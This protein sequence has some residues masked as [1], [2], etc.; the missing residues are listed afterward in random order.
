MLY[1]PAKGSEVP[2][3]GMAQVSSDTSPVFWAGYKIP[4]GQ[5]SNHPWGTGGDWK[6]TTAFYVTK[7]GFLHATN[8][9][10][11]GAIT[12]AAG[13]NIGG[14]K[15]AWLASD[16]DSFDLGG[17]WSTHF[18]ETSDIVGRSYK[19]YGLYSPWYY[20]GD[21]SSNSIMQ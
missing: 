15:V 13:G 1:A 7:E 14:W 10:I 8:A 17:F 6:L 21:S 19:G 12:A 5:S 2:G 20:I 16:S 9:E 3:T 4:Q 18:S 11:T